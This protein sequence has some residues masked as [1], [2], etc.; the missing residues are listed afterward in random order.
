MRRIIMAIAILA[1]VLGACAKSTPRTVNFY[2]AETGVGV[3]VTCEY[4]KFDGALR[5][6]TCTVI[7]LDDGL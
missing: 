7:I 2:D 1:I 4:F 5:H 6:D 3:S